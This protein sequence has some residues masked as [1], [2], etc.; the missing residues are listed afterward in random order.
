MTDCLPNTTETPSCSA[1]DLGCLVDENDVNT[2]KVTSCR[3]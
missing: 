3:E 2:K 1:S